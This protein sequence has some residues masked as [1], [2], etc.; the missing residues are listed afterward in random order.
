[1]TY[2]SFDKLWESEFD[3]IASKRGKLQDLNGIQLI[4]QAHASY[5]KDE[6][7]TLNFEASYPEDLINKAYLDEKLIKIDGHLSLLEKNYNESK[8]ISNKQTLEEVLIQSCENDFTNI[9]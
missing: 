6:K 9:S 4:L 8:I 3:N 5:R 2:I 7:I 1:M